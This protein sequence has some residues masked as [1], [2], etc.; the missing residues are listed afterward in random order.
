VRGANDVCPPGGDSGLRRTGG[1]KLHWPTM[2]PEGE[3]R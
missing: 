1:P 3:E 2:E